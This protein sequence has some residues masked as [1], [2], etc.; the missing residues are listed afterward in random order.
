MEVL[1]VTANSGV[2]LWKLLTW[3][4]AVSLDAATLALALALSFSEEPPVPKHATP[5][6]QCAQQEYFNNAFSGHQCGTGVLGACQGC[7]PIQCIKDER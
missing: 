1:A 3:K 4:A 2:I 5:A 7:V 6:L